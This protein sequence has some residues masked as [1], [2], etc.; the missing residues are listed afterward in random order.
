MRAPHITT[1]LPPHGP[2]GGASAFSLK[3]YFFV[4]RPSSGGGDSEATRSPTVQLVA[5]LDCSL[6]RRA[7][8]QHDGTRVSQ[9]R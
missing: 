4:S 7:V 2:A 9:R 1:H 6:Q 3:E 5:I 8:G